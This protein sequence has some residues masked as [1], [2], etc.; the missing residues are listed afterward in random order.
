MGRWKGSGVQ[1][2]ERR[3]GSSRAAAQALH[4]A[5]LR[6]NLCRA[7]AVEQRQKIAVGRERHGSRCNAGRG[8]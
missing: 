3:L 7:R 2:K 1:R 5:E 6:Y 8:K 4:A